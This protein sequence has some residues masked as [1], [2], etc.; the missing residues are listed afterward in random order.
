M[1]QVGSTAYL[2]ESVYKL[3]LRKSIPA[4]IRQL[5]LHISNNKGL[6]HGFVRELT[7]AKRNT[8]CEMTA[9]PLG[10]AG[11]P[12]APLPHTLAAPFGG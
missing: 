5:I 2:T 11:V 3:V 8:F 9:V 12:R 10:E 4:Q 1:F 7:F 6:V